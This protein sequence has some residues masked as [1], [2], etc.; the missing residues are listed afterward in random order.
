MNKQKILFL[1]LPYL[2]PLLISIVF[3]SGIEPFLLLPDYFKIAEANNLFVSYPF[4]VAHCFAIVFLSLL[5]AIFLF[6]DRKHV[7]G[8]RKGLFVC[9]VALILARAILQI[10]NS[11]FD[12]IC[13][14]LLILGYLGFLSLTR[15]W[16]EK[17]RMERETE[18]YL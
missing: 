12:F 17:E 7:A 16:M 3:Y 2:I 10:W 15:T 6:W 9:L 11:A 5:S 14:F 13:L 8:L 18:D 1:K 4:S